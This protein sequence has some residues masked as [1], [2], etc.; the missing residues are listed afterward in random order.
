MAA[1]R[2]TKMEDRESQQGMVNTLDTGHVLN[3]F[4]AND[5]ILLRI[6]T[7]RTRGPKLC[8]EPLAPLQLAASE[9]RT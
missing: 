9:R 7:T 5:V 2:S 8:S 3:I 1:K 6:S 4:H